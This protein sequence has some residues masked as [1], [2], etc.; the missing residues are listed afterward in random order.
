MP[1]KINWSEFDVEWYKEQYREVI[2]F[3]GL[4]TDQ[5]VME[6]YENNGATLTH[7]PNI[8]FDEK[9]YLTR[10]EDVKNLVVDGQYKTGF[11][12]Y[13]HVGYL[14]KS[15]HWLFDEEY[16]KRAVLD[17]SEEK[18]Q[19]KGFKNGYDHYLN[20]GRSLF[21]QPSMLFEPNLFL[22]ENS[23]FP[24]DGKMGAYISYLKLLPTQQYVSARLSWYFDPDW[25]V[26]N[27]PDV[28]IEN[29]KWL[30]PLHH[31]MTNNT[32]DLYDPNPYFSEKFYSKAYE[33][34]AAAVKHGSFRN[35]YEHFM[36]FGQYELRQPSED[37]RL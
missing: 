9:W 23:D 35:C 21:G 17:I 11:E 12:H 4:N 3:F 31:Y 7:S 22:Q 15:P 14:S 6:F 13:K 33:D 25:Y 8:F 29:N 10:Y 27:Y 18:L 28:F 19:E 16:Y 36:K 37:A 20:Q 32:P 2:S 34:V 24:L 5:E 1:E 30:G 26:K